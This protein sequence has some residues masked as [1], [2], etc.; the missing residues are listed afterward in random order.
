MKNNIKAVLFDMDGVLIDS[1]PLWKV[2]EHKVFEKVGISV[3]EKEMENT[4]GLRIDD[5][6]SY[7]KE[8][9]PNCTETTPSIVTAI[10]DEMVRLI[11]TEGRALLGVEKALN[12]F[13]NKGVKIGLATSSYTVLLD[14]VLTSLQISDYFDFTQSAEHLEYGKPHPEVY[15]KTAMALGEKPEN[16]LVIEDSY[17]GMIA[18]LS[19]KMRVAVIP[20]KSHSINPKLKLANFY[21]ENLIELV[22]FF[23][24]N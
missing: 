2:A 5:V 9:F 21:F 20:E 6:V 12:Y 23:D 17:N 13:E 10:M 4:V 22:N 18:G 8:Q 19:A 14:S 1:E 7:W 24:K 3:S 16:C 11:K 15:L